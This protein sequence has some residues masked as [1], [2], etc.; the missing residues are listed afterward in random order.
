MRTRLLLFLLLFVGSLPLYAQSWEDL[1]GLKTGDRIRVRDTAGREHKGKFAAVSAE[2]IS[3]QT[4]EGSTMI[5]RPRVERVRVSSGSRRIRNTVIGAAV[6]V[7]VG[8]AVDQT[9]GTRLR[10]EGNGSGRAATYLAPIGIFGGLG[11][12]RSAWRTAYRAP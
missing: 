2:A 7:A 12:A 6:G 11:A 1:R 3:L 4:E 8:V 10:N 5:E 9:L